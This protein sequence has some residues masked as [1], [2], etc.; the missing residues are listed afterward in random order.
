MIGTSHPSIGLLEGK[1]AVI[2]GTA[3][4]IGRATAEVFVREG[5]QVVVT[6]M[7]GGQD[8]TAE[9]LGEAAVPCQADI[10]DED[11][12]AGLFARALE[13]FGRVDASIHIA[14]NVG[15]RPSEEVTLQE[16]ERFTRV[17]LLGTMLCCKHAI[18][19][20]LRGGGGSIVNVSSVASLNASNTMSM[21]Y[22]AAKAGIN[23]LTKSFAVHHAEQGIRVNAILPGFTLSEKNQAIPREAMEHLAGLAALGRGAEPEEQAQAAAFLA[24]DRASFVTGAIIPV[25]GGWSATLAGG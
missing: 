22:A 13:Q 25:D 14:G 5:A 19:A 11:Q 18:K 17:H 3:G 9:G 24:S 1:V 20:M 2:T 8:E 23:S 15:G 7:S 16:Y 6:D 21:V 10:T 12:V 4:G